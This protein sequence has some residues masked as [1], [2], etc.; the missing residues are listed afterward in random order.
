MD[1]Q[2]GQF[3]CQPLEATHCSALDRAH[4]NFESI[5]LSEQ[6]HPSGPSIPLLFSPHS[7]FLSRL[8]VVAL[9]S[10]LYPSFA[11]STAFR[12]LAPFMRTARSGLS[13]GR[14]N[15]LQSA[16]KKQNAAGV[17]NLYRSYAV[18]ERTKPHVNIGT[19]GHVDH[20]K[21][22]SQP[23]S[24]PSSRL[25]PR[26]YLRDLRLTLP[27]PDHPVRCHHQASGREGICQLPRLWCH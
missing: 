8:L 13:A 7:P 18:F 24:Q 2:S 15:P 19:I 20:G 6:H 11:M 17:L 1:G 25:S 12:S 23:T 21:V 14:I 26:N 16:L 27:P 22:S 3:W 4:K 5:I 9:F 10:S